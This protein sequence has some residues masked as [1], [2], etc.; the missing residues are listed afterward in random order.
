MSAEIIDGKRI[1][2]EVR[3][4]IKDEVSKLERKPGLA[5]ILVGEDP[6]SKVYVNMKSIACEKVGFYSEKH[7]LPEDVSEEDLLKL[8]EEKNKD[9]KIDG[10]L[11]QLPL[12]K[13][14]DERRVLKAIDVNKDVDGFHPFNVGLLA[15]GT[16]YLV[17]ATAIGVLRLIEGV[18]EIVGK[19]AVVVG[20]S[21]IVGRPVAE[22]L[23]HR[24]ATVTVCHSKT[25]DLGYH[26]RNA[27]IL[28]VACGVPKLI[29]A[30]M[31]K[32]GAVVIDIGITRVEDGSEKG[33]HLEGDVDFDNVK[34]KVK[35]ITPV[36][37]GVGPMTIA[38]LLENTMTAYKNGK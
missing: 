32:E 35:S 15:N 27:E 25:K 28:V 3:E 26:T 13:R 37:G 16:P 29:K 4:K 1:A 11:V 22:M 24:R 21:N 7:K 17:P 8:I 10:I 6:A 23:M 38:M 31:V 12:P 19:E 14:I 2:S 5:V 34:E 36:P 33:Y 20:K 9:D 30:D 18:I